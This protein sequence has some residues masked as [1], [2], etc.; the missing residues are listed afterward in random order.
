[1]LVCCNPHC[2]VLH[3]SADTAGPFE[4]KGSADRLAVDVGGEVMGVS[5]VR[6]GIVSVNGASVPGVT[7]SVVESVV[8]GGAWQCSFVRA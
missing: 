8:V 7:V 1:M 3:G 6:S 4:A 5:V 2:N